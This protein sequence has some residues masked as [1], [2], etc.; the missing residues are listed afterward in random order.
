M[1]N[2]KIL[3]TRIKRLLERQNA[4]LYQDKSLLEAEYALPGEAFRPVQIGEAWGQPW[5][6][7]QFRVAGTVPASL[8]GKNYGLFFDCD[9]EA[10]VME[11]GT[12]LQ[13]LTPKV[14]WYH[15]AAK[16]Y[17]P[18]EAKVR[19][20][21]AFQLDI[22]ASANDLFGGGKAEFRLRECH[23]CTF[24]E[25]LFQRRMDIGLL[26]DLVESLPPGT[27]RRQ[28]IL[29]GLNRVCGLW[30]SNAEQARTI[31]A[32]LLSH[33]AHSSALT[34]FSVGHAHL[35]LAWLWPLRESHRKGGR[36]F[37]NA[38]RLLEQYPDYVFGA[39]QAQLYLWIKEDYPEL[40][41]Q[42]QE[43]VQQG[44]WEIQGASWVEFDTNLISAESIIRQFMYGKRFFRQEFGAE[45]LLL[46][47]PDCFGFSGNL[48][49]LM[50]GCGVPWFMT[51]K[52][53]WNESNAF[54]HH[55]FNWEGIDGSRVL[56]HQLP[57]NDYNFSNDPSAFLQTEQRYAQSGICDAFLN[58]F[59]IGDGGGGPTRNHIEYGLRMQD[60]EG[61]SKF[62]FATGAQFFEHVSR[63][64]KALLPTAYGELYLEFHRGTYTTQARMKQDNRSSEK[65]LGAAEYLAV[66]AG[67]PYPEA[68][69]Q[70]WQ[71][72]LLLQFH[73]II[74]GSS[75][76]MV[77]ADAQAISAANHALLRDYLTA[78]ATELAQDGQ[79]CQ[80][81]AYLVLNPSNQEITAWHAFPKELRGLVP[82]NEY[83]TQMN[84]LETE[85][86][87]LAK[88]KVPAWGSLL[89]RFSDDSYLPPSQ[90]LP[91][92][93][94]LENP[95]LK[96]ELTETGGIRSLWDKELRREVL[97]AESNLLLLWEDEPN[98]WGAWDIN[99]FYRDTEPQRASSATLN[100]DL[101]INLEGGFSRLVHDIRIGSST[102]RQTIE[103]RCDERMLRV[104]HEI[105]WQERHK[106]LRTHWFPAVYG[107]VATYGI[108]GG[109]IKRSSKPKNAWE[110]AQFEV[111]AQRFAD[112]SQ[113]DYGCA[114]LC[115]VKFGYRIVDSQLELNLLRSP[116]DVD[117]SADIHAHAY[118]YAFYPHPGDYEHSDVFNAAERIAH[119]L[120]IV[121]VKSLPR[122]RSE[123]LFRLDSDHV[124]LDAVK[125]AESGNGI[126]LRFHEYKGQSG[127]ARLHCARN[128]VSC[129]E[130]NML[131]EPL[132]ADPIR[133]EEYFPLCLEFRPFEI[134]T[135]ILREEP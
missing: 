46:W 23:L 104:S 91:A 93:L 94:T 63:L 35:D 56:A 41:K 86:A 121:P 50:Q 24:D 58:L 20:G 106:M 34:A 92:S 80:D 55:L 65:L 11:G 62:K 115:D 97:A 33:P 1:Q 76:T 133:I 85:T 39:S 28:R 119:D 45:P 71:D 5:Q 68:L 32:E 9:G 127:T 64:D 120:V 30:Q 26:L 47:L 12:P 36:T 129:R 135:I 111:P 43:R 2:E 22:A 42:V 88:L 73:D 54:P 52:L 105:D 89:L 123:P 101:S 18:L 99:H 70:I 75:I 61:V 57:T 15:K 82:L 6:T 8:S 29:H 132:D 13:G 107:G 44:R 53:S 108:Q 116:A 134:K 95:Y 66:L 96:V 37:A 126:V 48:P 83:S 125:P 74:P 77:Y 78:T 112:L 10:C 110:E 7:A 17:V 130:T 118:S 122:E 100:Q 117:P 87:L 40:Y 67:K 19:P 25:E 109:V 27:V 60:L 114:L 59:G 69:R 14:D 16:H 102:L 72:T 31:L 49:Q 51:Q 81:P 113:P 38:L 90:L 124:N 103:L 128:Y 4:L 98:N 79:S 3:I 84:S 21:A 131:E